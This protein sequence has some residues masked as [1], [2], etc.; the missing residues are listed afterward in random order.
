MKTF[1]LRMCSREICPSLRT[2]LTARFTA[3]E[4]WSITL[5]LADHFL[6]IHRHAK[7]A[8]FVL[9]MTYTLLLDVGYWYGKTEMVSDVIDHPQFKLHYY[10]TMIF[11]ELFWWW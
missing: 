5:G 3:N 9:H 6:I 11:F 10:T 4:G 2:N 7:K 8:G 1:P